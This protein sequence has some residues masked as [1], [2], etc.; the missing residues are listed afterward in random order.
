MNHFLVS[1]P[2]Q[3]AFCCL[4]VAAASLAGGWILLVVRLTHLRLQIASSFVAG[5][6]LAMALRR[7]RYSKPARIRR[8]SAKPCPVSGSTINST[9]PSFNGSESK[10]AFMI[11]P[12]DENRPRTRRSMVET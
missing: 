8:I 5:L 7:A 3:P 6:M 9:S 4:L 12:W 2:A 11:S 10:A 1:P